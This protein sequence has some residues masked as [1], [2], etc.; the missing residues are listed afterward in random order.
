MSVGCAAT[1]AGPAAVRRRHVLH[2]GA[3]L[4]GDQCAGGVVPRRE[5]ELPVRVDLAGGDVAEVER[6]R[7]AAADVADAAQRCGEHR[8]LALAL[9]GVVGEPGGHE[10]AREVVQLARVDGAVVADGAVPGDRPVQPSGARVQDHSHHG[11]AVDLDG[12]RRGVGGV[13]VDV[14]GG[15]VERVDDPAHPARALQQAALLSEQAVARPFGAEAIDDEGLG[16]L[17]HLAD[18]VGGRGLGLDGQD[19][20]S[21]LSMDASRL[22]REVAR[23]GEQLAQL[24]RRAAEG[25]VVGHRGLLVVVWPGLPGASAGAARDRSRSPAGVTNTVPRPARAPPFGPRR[26]RDGAREEH[27]R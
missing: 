26:H 10:R 1:T 23:Q 3:R 24:R 25:V 12:D 7:P 19:A 5:V 18:H 13:A 22:E 15:T 6:G 4:A 27:F 2:G 16:L 17:V 8:A 9:L 14:V 20:P 11:L 21:A